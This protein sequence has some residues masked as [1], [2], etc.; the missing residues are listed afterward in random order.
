MA[1]L[2]DPD[3]PRVILPYVPSTAAAARRA[4]MARTRTRLAA[5]ISDARRAGLSIAPALDRR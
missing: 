1:D 2:T 3:T 4:E 5:S